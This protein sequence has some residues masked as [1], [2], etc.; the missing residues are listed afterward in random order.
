MQLY[1]A[2]IGSLCIIASV[3]LMLR[4]IRVL[5]G[6]AVASGVVIGHESRRVDESESFLPVIRFQ[7]S[8]GVDFE[9]TS[10][11]GRAVARPATGSQVRVRFLP[12]NPKNAYI[13]TI[14][15]MWAAPLALA[16]LGV[17]GVAA[18]LSS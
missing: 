13:S 8:K 3:V 4:R 11:A 15:H 6:G 18:L 2:V 16:V 1:F 17:A 12:S 10:V 14:L 7:D 9:F 5:L